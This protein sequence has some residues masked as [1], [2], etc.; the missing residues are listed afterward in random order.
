MII[1]FYASNLNFQPIS[2]ELKCNFLL[3]T[4]F[5]LL[6]SFV[7]LSD[8]IVRIQIVVLFKKMKNLSPHFVTFEKPMKIGNPVYECTKTVQNL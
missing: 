5:Q 1:L 3:I 2:S 4:M 6:I 8:L 7:N